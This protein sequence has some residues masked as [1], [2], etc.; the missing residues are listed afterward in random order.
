M[1]PREAMILNLK[2]RVETLSAENVQ[3]RNVLKVD[4]SNFSVKTMT[5]RKTSA[6]SSE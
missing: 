4:D 1:D 3:L 2:R 6:K 5:P